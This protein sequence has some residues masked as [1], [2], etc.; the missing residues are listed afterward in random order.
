MAIESDHNGSDNRLAVKFYRDTFE[1]IVATQLQGRA[2]YK[3]VDCIKIIVPGDSLSEIDR[4][5]LESD[6]IRF[7]IQWANFMNRQGAEGKYEGTPLSEWPLITRSQAEGLRSQ[8][9]YTVE[10][11]ATGSDQQLQSIGMLAGMSP[12]TLRDKAKLFLESAKTA[13]DFSNREQEIATLKAENDKIK[14]ETDAKI[15]A[16]QAEFDAKLT[17]LLAAV[18]EKPPRRKKAKGIETT[19]EG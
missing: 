5:V 4:P 19:Q 3:E 16:M 13:A 12:Y 10:S 1:D 9:F 17:S 8:K 2:I 18:S 14:A 15:A 6:K 11:I 7:P